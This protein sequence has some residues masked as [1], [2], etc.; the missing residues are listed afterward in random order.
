MAK[1]YIT[2]WSEKGE[3]GRIRIEK[4]LERKRKRKEKKKEVFI[5]E[6]CGDVSPFPLTPVEDPY[7]KEI[8]HTSYIARMCGWCYDASRGD[9]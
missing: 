8:Q 7:S 9:I 5:C 1:D 3:Y 4:T 2:Y 6:K